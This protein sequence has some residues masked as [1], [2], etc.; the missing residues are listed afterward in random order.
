MNWYPFMAPWQFNVD[1]KVK[2]PGHYN[3]LGFPQIVWL[4]VGRTGFASDVDG[5]DRN[6]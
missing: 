1:V 5:P 6:E 3:S 2:E 4:L